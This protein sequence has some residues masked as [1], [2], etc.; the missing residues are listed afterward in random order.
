[1][2]ILQR[3]VGES[4]VIGED[5][6]VS[7]VSV[8]G[9]RVRLAITA[10]ENVPI[11]RSELVVATAA[12]RDAAIVETAPTELLDL[13]GA[14]ENPERPASPQSDVFKQGKEE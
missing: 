7:I 14:L 8:D 4:L 12:N 6:T 3:R 5:I 10:P 13:L 2:L 1:M 11:L 9:M